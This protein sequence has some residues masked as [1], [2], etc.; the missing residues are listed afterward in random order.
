VHKDCP[1]HLGREPATDKLK[2][3]ARTGCAL[4]AGSPTALLLQPQA[5]ASIHVSHMRPHAAMPQLLSAHEVQT[6]VHTAVGAQRL[7]PA[8]APGGC[9]ARVMQHTRWC[10]KLWKVGCCSAADACTRLISSHTYLSTSRTSTSRSNIRSSRKAGCSTPQARH[11]VCWG[12]QGII[13]HLRAWS[14]RWTK[15]CH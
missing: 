14:R 3:L 15:H 9:C 6:Y 5:Q 11:I 12:P 2:G 4:Q 7:Q 10:Q 13:V 1:E 8:S